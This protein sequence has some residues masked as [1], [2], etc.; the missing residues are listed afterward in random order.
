MKLKTNTFY[1]P[2][3]YQKNKG[4]K[5]C[6]LPLFLVPVVGHAHFVCCLL[7]VKHLRTK[8]LKTAVSGCFLTLFALLGFKSLPFCM[9]QKSTPKGCFFGGA[10]F[11]GHHETFQ[12]S[13][14]GSGNPHGQYHPRERKYFGRV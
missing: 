3:I 7:G 5:L 1:V 11:F 8:K 10:G 4:T 14:T 6:W 9:H 13:G 2:S 12:R